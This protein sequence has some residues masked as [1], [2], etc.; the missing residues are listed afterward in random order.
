[1]RWLQAAIVGAAVAIAALAQSANPTIKYRTVV[2]QQTQILYIRNVA[3]QYI[4][5]RQILHAIPAWQHA[6]NVDFARY[7]HTTRFQLV[8]IGTR[9][10]PVGGMQATFVGKGPVKGALAYHWVD[11]NAPSITVYAGTGDY[12]GYSN[13][14][15]FTHELFELAADPVTSLVNQG[16]PYD[17]YWLE[18]KDMTIRMAPQ[19]GVYGWFNEVCDP[20]EADYY[21]IGDVKISDFITPSWFNDGVGQRYDFMGVAKQPFWI[22]PGGYAQYLGANGWEVITNFRHGHP[23]DSGFFKSDPKGRS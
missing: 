6:V 17:Y 9:K 5:D 14:V 23:A 7:W 12:Y 15:S 21:L 10:A 8:F 4:S 22:R 2:K 11:G 16:W 3:Q 19:F 13:S 1:M 18:G 20:V